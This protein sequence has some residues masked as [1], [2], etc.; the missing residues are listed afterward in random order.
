MEILR[1][2]I[3]VL[4]ENRFDTPERTINMVLFDGTCEG[5]FFNGTILSGGVD[6]QIYEKDKEGTLSARYII[7]GVDKDGA[8][9]HLFIENNGIIGKEETKTYPKIYTDSACL[10]WLETQKLEGTLE[11]E[12]DKIII[13]IFG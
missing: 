7:E 9:C 11:V 3:H 8:A 2:Y 5:E 12:Q 13:R 4:K 6:T 1:L 10:K